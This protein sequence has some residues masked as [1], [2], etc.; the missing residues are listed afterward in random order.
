M[1]NGAL[2]PK[3]QRLNFPYHLMFTYIQNDGLVQNYC[4]SFTLVE[5]LQLLQVIEY[6][7]AVAM[8]LRYIYQA[9]NFENLRLSGTTPGEVN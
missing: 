2:T 4:T 5:E 1:E 8:K 7:N 9:V 3:E 6:G